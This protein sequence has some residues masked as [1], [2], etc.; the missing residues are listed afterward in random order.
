MFIKVHLVSGF[1][2][3]PK[4]FYGGGWLFSFGSLAVIILVTLYCDIS[5]SQCSDKLRTYSL[6]KIG[7]KALGK[8]GK[9]L[10]EIIIA[11]TQVNKIY[12]IR[13]LFLVA[14]PV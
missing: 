5:I 2:F 7:Y 14:M 11:I 13:W 12:N 1:L 8:T 10:V 9:Y 4:G 6:A 3:L